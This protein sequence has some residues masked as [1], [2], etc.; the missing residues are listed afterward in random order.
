M[1]ALQDIFPV[2]NSILI[3]P[4]GE[5]SHKH[6][7]FAYKAQRT[8]HLSRVPQV[9]DGRA[10]LQIQVDM[11]VKPFVIMVLPSLSET[12]YWSSRHLLWSASCRKQVTYS[13]GVTEERLMKGLFKKIWAGLR[14]TNK[15]WWSPLTLAT[16]GI[17][18]PSLGLRGG[19]QRERFLEPRQRNRSCW[20]EWRG[21]PC[22]N[23]NLL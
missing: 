1:L 4:L 6:P 13:D 3:E 18:L 22:R 5:K 10:G 12:I 14:E 17:L 23:V 9:E 11:I 19:K 7:H 16:A 20:R 15:G 2:L 8:C 21:P